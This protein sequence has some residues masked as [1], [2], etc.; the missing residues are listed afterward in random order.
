[1]P[2]NVYS[3]NSR[4][5]RR[6][7]RKF[8]RKPTRA[9]GS[10]GYS[11]AMAPV[12]K[13][14]VVMGNAYNR[15]TPWTGRCPIPST[16][17]VDFFWSDIYNLTTGSGVYGTEQRFRLNSLYDPDYTTVIFDHSV[18]FLSIY[19][20]QYQQYRVDEVDWEL[21]FTTPGSEVDVLCSATMTP[22]TSGSL[23]GASRYFALQ[24]PEAQTGLLSPT[25]ERRCTLR[26]T[27]KL[28]QLFGVERVKYISEDDYS[29]GIGTNPAAAALLS[30]AV[31]ATNGGAAIACSVVATIKYKTKLY[32]RLSQ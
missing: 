2:Y 6:I 16:Q 21:V 18:K 20:A 27:I 29:S 7:V 3:I 22:N 15:F 30:C 10:R 25:G 28:H 11:K 13:G 32:N 12:N 17:Y 8:M 23:A 4:K 1:M 9:V 5:G 31:I 24:S 14:G 26:G 19:A